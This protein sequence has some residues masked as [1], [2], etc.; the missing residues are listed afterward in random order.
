MG[1][2]E[3]TLEKQQWYR[4]YNL[5]P[6]QAWYRAAGTSPLWAADDKLILI[7]NTDLF[8]GGALAPKVRV[9]VEWDEQAK[10]TPLPTH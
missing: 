8:S 2:I 6:G 7:M 9:I 4:R 3:M 1:K 10:A 5:Y